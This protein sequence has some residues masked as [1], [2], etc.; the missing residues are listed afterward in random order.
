MFEG[1]DFNKQKEIYPK[2]YKEYMQTKIERGRFF[3]RFPEGES[4]E[5]VC[6]RIKDLVEEV[7]KISETKNVIIIS[8]ATTIKCFLL[9]WF[10]Y[11]PYMWYK[12]EPIPSNC[13][14]RLI[15]NSQIMVIFMSLKFVSTDIFKTKKYICTFYFY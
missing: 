9:V 3:A 11:S 13:S 12:N 6:N 15:N 7:K 1:L 14:I 4:P 5:D 10:N 2:L 8:H